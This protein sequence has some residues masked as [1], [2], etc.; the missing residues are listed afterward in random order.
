[1]VVACGNV[2][3][4][5]FAV[6]LVITLDGIVVA[7]IKAAR[8]SKRHPGVGFASLYRALG[9][10]CWPSSLRCPFILSPR[11]EAIYQ[12]DEALRT[13]V[14]GLARDGKALF[15]HQAVLYALMVA[16][17]VYLRGTCQS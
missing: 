14:H 4:I 11:A 16:L 8:V 12:R 9:L 2:F 1:M 6:Y 13:D 7:A 3:G 17:Y 15:F 5:C 10:W